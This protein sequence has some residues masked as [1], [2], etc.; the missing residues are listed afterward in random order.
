MKYANR[1]YNV[2]KSY[3]REILKVTE[4][5]EVISFAGGLPNPA[6]FPVDGIKNATIK[7]ME[8]FGKEALQYSTTEGYQPLRKYIAERY[9]KRFGLKVSEDE[10]LITTGSQQ[11]LD[12]I[13]KIFIDPNDEVIVEKP[14]YLGAIQ[15][16]SVFEPTYLSVS[17]ENDGINLLELEK[18]LDK[19]SPK[20][21]YAVPNFQNPTGLT[22]TEDNLIKVSDMMKSNG[23]TILIADDPYGEL[24]FCGKDNNSVKSF[25]GEQSILLGSFSKIVSPGMR[26]GWIC[27]SPEI[28]DRLVTVKQ[29]ADLHTNYFTQRVLYQ[30]LV[31]NDLDEHIKSIKNLY[32]QQKQIMED[33]IKE[34]FPKNVD[35]TKPE[36]GMF[37]WVTLPQGISAL[38]LLEKAAEKNVAFVPGDPFYVDQ[39][40]VNSLRLNYTNSTQ[41]EINEGIRNLGDVLKAII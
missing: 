9:Y 23:N 37:L 19:H 7:V 22:Y 3:I 13:G 15:A 4:K 1:M 26:I 41:D 35:V 29:A 18:V 39:E 16:L 8:K 24:R 31:D 40:N 38:S 25:L 20:L 27:A 5:P 17:L 28:I 10:I 12:L 6:T 11:G 14:G 34:Y 21:F 2:K 32:G 36:G 30:Y 33:A